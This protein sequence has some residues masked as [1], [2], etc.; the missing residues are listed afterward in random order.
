MRRPASLA[1]ALAALLAL[2]VLAA[3][4]SKHV[5]MSGKAKFAASAEENYQAGMELLKDE[6]YPD[7]QKF[8]EYV[9]TKFPF[10]KFAALADLRLADAKFDQQLWAEAV[11]AY[12]QFLQ[13]HPNHEDADYAEFRMAKAHFKDAPGD[14]V[15]FPPASEKDQRQAEKAATA[16]ESFIQKYPGSKYLPE[17]QKL[18]EEAK[19]RLA[20]REWH[21]GEFYY[22]RRRWAGAAGRF[23]TLVDKYPGS[24]HEV[25]ALLKLADAAVRID[26]KHRARTALQKLI[27]R[28]PQDPRRGEAEKLLAAL[29]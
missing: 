11:E 7:A 22:K 12:N 27:V 5:T 24:R 21:V 23:E 19:G 9:K 16:L 6:A 2:A 26:E 4:G 8:F 3:C 15:L 13:L 28:H 17:A 18:L 29:R 14:F 25:D 20:E 1:A 10:S